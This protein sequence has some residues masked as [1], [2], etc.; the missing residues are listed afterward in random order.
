MS[1]YLH[2]QEKDYSDFPD[3]HNPHTPSESA[4]NAP[5]KNE[6][7]LDPISTHSTKLEEHRTEERG[8]SWE[9]DAVVNLQNISSAYV[10]S[11]GCGTSDYG[12]GT[13]GYGSTSANSDFNISFSVLEMDVS[14]IGFHSRQEEVNAAMDSPKSVLLAYPQATRSPELARSTRIHLQGEEKEEEEG[15]RQYFILDSPLSK[16]ASS[17]REDEGYR[18]PGNFEGNTD[19]METSLSYEDLKVVESNSV[20]GANIGLDRSCYDD[21]YIYT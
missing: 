15:D 6:Y 17:T 2:L 21:S 5:C 18:S 4:R 8:V 3:P 19:Y 13:S 7:V 1:V 10:G 11:S 9:P 16:G 20:G 14:T 12:C